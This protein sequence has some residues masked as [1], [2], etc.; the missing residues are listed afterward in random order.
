MTRIVAYAHRPKRPPR[1]Q[2]AVAFEV[3]AVAKV[4]DPAKVHT[5]TLA[6]ILAKLP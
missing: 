1:K 5:S 4:A 3:P 6:A 2:P